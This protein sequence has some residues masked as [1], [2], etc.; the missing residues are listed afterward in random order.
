AEVGGSD[1][2]SGG[3]T[4]SVVD[5]DLEDGDVL[6]AVG[7][8]NTVAQGATFSGTVATFHYSGDDREF[9]T[10]ISWADG[11]YDDGVKIDDG[12]H[13]YA[14]EGAY[15]VAVRVFDESG[16]DL[17][18]GGA[19]IVL[20]VLDRTRAQTLLYATIDGGALFNET[21]DDSSVTGSGAVT[22]TLQSDY[23]EGFG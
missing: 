6:T 10:G 5:P 21:V 23:A 2:F 19:A 12:G 22:F 3:G 14:T 1:S 20:P 18:A 4:I 13:A 15:A 8:N 11:S 16:A 17:R 7:V 9:T